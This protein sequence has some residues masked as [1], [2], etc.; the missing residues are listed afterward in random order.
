MANIGL[1][2]K[3][4][5]MVMLEDIVKAK[6]NLTDSLEVETE[7]IYKDKPDSCPHCESNFITGVEV[8]GGYDGVLLWECDECDEMMLRFTKDTT[9]KYLQLAKGLWTNPEDWG[10]VPRSKFN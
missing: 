5:R 6:D 3:N 4:C 7:L 8:M 1:A 2:I 9:E 10:Y